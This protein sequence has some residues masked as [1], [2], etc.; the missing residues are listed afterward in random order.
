MG[1]WRFRETQFWTL[2]SQLGS[3]TE[4]D[5]WVRT[6]QSAMMEM[7]NNTNQNTYV[8]HVGGSVGGCEYLSMLDLLDAANDTQ[9]QRNIWIG[10]KNWL[11]MS[12][13]TSLM[14]ITQQFQLKVIQQRSNYR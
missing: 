9:K 2:R 10:L 1:S 6:N 11:S 8:A 3:C 4:H 12:Q 14:K 5:A 7:M 13:Y